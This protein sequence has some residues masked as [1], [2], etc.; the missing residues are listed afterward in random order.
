[1]PP[2]PRGGMGKNMDSLAN[3]RDGYETILR[4]F[5]DGLP[6]SIMLHKKSD[7]AIDI[8]AEKNSYTNTMKAGA[9]GTAFKN[10]GSGCKAGA[11]SRFPQN[12][13]RALLMLYTKPG[14]I[15]VDP[16]AGHN[17]RMELCWRAGRNY[18]GQDLCAEFMDANRK[19]YD[20]LIKEREDDMFPGTCSHAN[21]T[22]FEGDSRFMQAEDG[23]G[24]FTITSPPYW[25]Q[26]YY[27]PEKEQLGTGEGGK[28][29]EGF[30]EGL[31]QVMRENFR[32]L[33]SGAFCVWCI[34][35]FRSKGKFYSYHE[36]TAVGLRQAGFIQWDISI[37]D[38]GSSMR[39]NFPNQVIEQKILPKRHEYCLIFRKP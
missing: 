2:T 7:R 12:V 15:V 24:D 25:A 31:Y 33:K 36:D 22:L 21:V 39:Q 29:Y 37:T 10:S 18:I 38:L 9:A 17:S 11:L 32:C 4:Q 6:Q 13:G 23:Q 20:M 26:E 16:F 8:M 19:I 28:A 30:L 14:D 5:K 34:N 3:S 27:G 35:D 1:M